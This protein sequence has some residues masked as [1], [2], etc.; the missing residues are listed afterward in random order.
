MEYL[1]EPEEAS[2]QPSKTWPALFSTR[3]SEEYD[4]ILP[5]TSLP[6]DLEPPLQEPGLALALEKENRIVRE[7]EKDLQE[8]VKEITRRSEVLDREKGLQVVLARMLEVQEDKV[9]KIKELIL[10]HHDKQLS[11]LKAIKRAHILVAR[12]KKNIMEHLD[13]LRSLADKENL[14]L[15]SISQFTNRYKENLETD[16]GLGLNDFEQKLEN[17]RRPN[18]NMIL[19]KNQNA[20]KNPIMKALE[21]Y[22]KKPIR[23]AQKIKGMNKIKSITVSSFLCVTRKFSPPTGRDGK[24]C[25]QRMRRVC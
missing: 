3:D 8:E 17:K 16:L 4:Q 20:L 7:L 14:E 12:G 6:D 15:E 24:R 21:H 2:L 25:T 19:K 18:K 9:E 11:T 1:Y 23:S 22:L 13:Q 10:E 5:E